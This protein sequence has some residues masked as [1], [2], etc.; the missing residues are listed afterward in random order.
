VHYNQDWA[1]GALQHIDTN[2]GTAHAARFTVRWQQ[3][4]GPNH[5]IDEKE[6]MGTMC[7]LV[8]DTTHPPQG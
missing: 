7:A 4:A 1:F 6:R 5:T 2:L 8:E 3:W